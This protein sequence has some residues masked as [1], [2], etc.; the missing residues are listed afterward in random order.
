[1]SLWTKIPAQLQRP[2]KVLLVVLGCVLALVI[3]F[4]VGYDT[5][6]SQYNVPRTD[7]A[8][9]APA[10][11]EVLDTPGSGGGPCSGG[12]TPAPG[13]C[14]R[15]YACAGGVAQLRRCPAH[16]HYDAGRGACVWI[17]L[18]SCDGGAA[19]GP[20]PA[21]A[22]APASDLPPTLA[23]VR[24]EEA[25]LAQGQLAILRKRL[26]TL[27]SAQ[28]QLETVYLSVEERN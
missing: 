18:S 15:Y 12:S 10:P 20:A 4:L 13:D 1:M 2:V 8:G 19:A 26:A 6:K 16:H 23:M 25:R 24:A 27:P 9:V 5:A 11:A 22:P 21:P 7:G 28:V 3:A 17:H 14:A